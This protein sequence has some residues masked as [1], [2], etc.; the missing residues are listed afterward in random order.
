MQGCFS[1]LNKGGILYLDTPCTEF[2]HLQ[3]KDWHHFKTRNEF[4]HVILYSEAALRHVLKIAGFKIMMLEKF[5]EY[6][7]MQVAAWKE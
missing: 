3:G 4:E 1:R 5:D 7:S 6:A 2:I